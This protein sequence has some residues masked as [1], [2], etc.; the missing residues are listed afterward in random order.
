MEYKN[1][2]NVRCP[3]CSYPVQ[4]DKDFAIKNKRIFCGTCCKSFDVDIQEDQREAD[5]YKKL[6]SGTSEVNKD[7]EEDEESEDELT[8]LDLDDFDIPF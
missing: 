3:F 4:S 2:I 8:T 1:P 5:W 6:I 7:T